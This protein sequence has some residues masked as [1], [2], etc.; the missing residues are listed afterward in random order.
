MD[1]DQRLKLPLHLL[2]SNQ[3]Q[4]SAFQNSAVNTNRSDTAKVMF[5]GNYSNRTGEHMSSFNTADFTKEER[6]ETCRRNAEG[7]VPGG[8]SHCTSQAKLSK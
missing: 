3:H 2:Q 8:D 4:L 1:E 7:K 6:V 5:V